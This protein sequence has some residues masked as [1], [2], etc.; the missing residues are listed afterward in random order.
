MRSVSHADRM[1]LYIS[2]R[3]IA[4]DLVEERNE[5]PEHSSEGDP[6]LLKVT[7]LNRQNNQSLHIFSVPW[8]RE[9]TSW[10]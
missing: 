7:S 9:R 10:R 6:G 3:D 4:L 2:P 5:R 1:K 8:N